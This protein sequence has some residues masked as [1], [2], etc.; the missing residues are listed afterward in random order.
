MKQAALMVIVLM[1]HP[2]IAKGHGLLAVGAF[3]E[4]GS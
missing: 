1:Y 3:D 2:N 4:H